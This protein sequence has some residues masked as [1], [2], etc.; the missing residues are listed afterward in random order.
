MPHYM[1]N[2][3]RSILI[4]FQV[5][6]IK[7]TLTKPLIFLSRDFP[8]RMFQVDVMKFFALLKMC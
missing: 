3:Q 7:L 2:V 4:A 1:Y 6:K 5:F 8:G